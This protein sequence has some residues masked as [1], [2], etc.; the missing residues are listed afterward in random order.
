MRIGTTPIHTFNLP[1]DTENIK[2][3][4]ITYAQDG[5]I[6]LQ[7]T[8]DDCECEGTVVTLQ[9]TQ[10]DTFKFHHRDYV[11]LQIRSKLNDGNVLESDIYEVDPKECLS[12]EIL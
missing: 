12:K 1:I 6:K 11:R 5:E 2:E 3:L 10:E 8:K 7:K 4:E 9:L